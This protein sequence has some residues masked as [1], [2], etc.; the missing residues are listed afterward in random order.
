MG[1]FGCFNINVIRDV[2]EFVRVIS[3]RKVCWSFFV[4]FLIICVLGFVKEY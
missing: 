3:D 2:V 1:F 4:Y